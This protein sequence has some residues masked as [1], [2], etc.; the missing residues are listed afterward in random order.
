MY[1]EKSTTYNLEGSKTKT[2]IRIFFVRNPASIIFMSQI[3]NF[4]HVYFLDQSL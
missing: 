4:M 2:S 1:L 3:N